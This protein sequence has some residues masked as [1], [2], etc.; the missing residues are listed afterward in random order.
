MLKRF[1]CCCRYIDDLCLVNNDNLMKRCMTDI[2]P[3]ELKLVPDDSHGLHAPFL[4]LNMTIKDGC[5]YTSIFDKRDNFDF[6]I[7]NFPTLSGNIPDASAYGVFVGELVRHV[8]CM[9]ILRLGL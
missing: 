3:E 5:I 2:Y 4:D 8:L 9:M 7:V 1:Q 6:P